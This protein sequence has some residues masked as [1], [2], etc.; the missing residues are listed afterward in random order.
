MKKILWLIFL[1]SLLSAVSIEGHEAL[2]T[3]I[4]GQGDIGIKEKTGQAISP[5]ITFYY[6]KGQKVKMG[7]RLGKPVIL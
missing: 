4:S 3:G 6:E 5:D 2:D 7:D 1:L